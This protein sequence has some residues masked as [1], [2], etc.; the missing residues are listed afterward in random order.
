[1]CFATT[2]SGQAFDVL[3][4]LAFHTFCSVGQIQVCVWRLKWWVIINGEWFRFFVGPWSWC[5]IR[6][7]SSVLSHVAAVPPISFSRLHFYIVVSVP[8]PC[9]LSFLFLSLLACSV[10]TFHCPGALVVPFSPRGRST[11][12]PCCC[13]AFAHR[14]QEM[15][16]ARMRPPS[17]AHLPSEVKRT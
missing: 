9:T 2:S 3:V 1:M 11:T 10:A 17:R 14:I 8:S 12:P 16:A 4:L 7:L 6:T 13:S 5:S 15:Q